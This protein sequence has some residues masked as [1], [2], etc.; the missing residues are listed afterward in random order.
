MQRHLAHRY[1]DD[2]EEED[3]ENV[4]PSARRPRTARSQAG[5]GDPWKVSR[6]R[7]RSRGGN[8]DDEED[9][10]P[11]QSFV[12][13]AYDK[14]SSLV[15]SVKGLFFTGLTKIKSIIGGREG[16][17]DK[18]RTSR[19]QKKSRKRDGS[20]SSE[21]SMDRYKT[22]MGRS[23]S[24]GFSKVVPID[25]LEELTE[26]EYEERKRQVNF[27]INRV[28]AIS[29]ERNNDNSREISSRRAK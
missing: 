27:N 1:E 13:L 15:T 3:E 5:L 25:I 20:L 23:K 11:K 24:R 4:R 7:E 12:E 17:R 10:A 18:S 2:I 21:S 16:G 26:E 8:E 22:P 9:D 14:T 6:S 29:P 28:T 19:S